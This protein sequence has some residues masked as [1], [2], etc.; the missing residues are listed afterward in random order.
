MP[1]RKCS[2]NCGIER[3][4]TWLVGGKRTEKAFSLD[5]GFIKFFDDGSCAVSSLCPVRLITS[6]QNSIC[7]SVCTLLF[8]CCLFFFLG[9]GIICRA[10]SDLQSYNLNNRESNLCTSSE[11]IQAWTSKTNMS[12]W[13]VASRSS[14]PFKLPARSGWCWIRLVKCFFSY[15]ER[16]RK[17]SSCLCCPHPP[18]VA[19]QSAE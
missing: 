2:W 4:N 10:Y 12:F 15:G 6:S 1:E 17:Y 3:K 13:L 5:Y 11:H 16:N 18:W 8:V 19:P 9:D 7:I 14:A